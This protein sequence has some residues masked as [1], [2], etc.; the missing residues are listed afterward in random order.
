MDRYVQIEFDSLSRE[1]KEMIIALL[2]EMNYQGF[3]EEGDLLRAYIFSTDFSGK[4]LNNLA[5]KFSLNF[6]ISEVENRNWNEEWESNFHPVLVNHPAYNDPWVAIRAG[7]HKPIKNVKHEI[8]ITPKMSFGTGHHAT[9]AMMIRAMGKLS[10]TGRR[11]L[12]FGTGT[13]ILAILAEKLGASK[14][15]AIDNDDQ[16]IQNAEENILANNCSKIQL[17]KAS[18]AIFPLEFDVVLANIVKIVI[19]SNLKAFTEQLVPGGKVVLSGLLKDD[20]EEVLQ[21]SRNNSLL[22]R[23]KI[24]E[25]NWICLQLVYEPTPELR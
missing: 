18:V 6:S 2:T 1:Q 3:E 19:L 14:V 20:E 25:E 9:T 10:F 24:E 5:K 21:W 12:D 7:F 16:S 15:V 22:L 8:I 4:E 11:V 13:G 23:E 17:V